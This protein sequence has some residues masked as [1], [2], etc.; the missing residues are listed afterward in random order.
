MPDRAI[1][2]ATLADAPAIAAIY[3]HHVRH[4]TATFEIVP[5]GEAE[6]ASRMATI[7]GKG[8]PWLVARDGDGDVI[9][10]AYAGQYAERAAYRYACESSIYLRNDRLGQGTGTQLLRALIAACEAC[11]FRQMVAL[12]AGTGPASSA[13]HSAAGFRACGTL[14]SVG[15]KH[16]QWIDVIQMQLPLGPGDALPPSEEP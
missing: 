7:Q 3:A 6:I 4:G 16:G 8:W 14:A 9:G 15:R 13:L 5:P 12:I 10:Y 2:P 11:G 1:S